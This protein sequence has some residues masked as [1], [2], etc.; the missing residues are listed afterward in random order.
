MSRPSLAIPLGAIEGL[1][2]RNVR[3]AVTA[4]DVADLAASIGAVDLIHPLVVEA[5]PA[6]VGAFGRVYR[7]LDG[8]RR[9]MALLTMRD[10]LATIDDSYRV[11]CVVLEADDEDDAREISLAANVLRRDLHPVEEFE[12]FARL[13]AEG[14]SVEVIAADFGRSIRFVRQ[15][16]A[17]DRLSPRVRALWREG[18]IG[19]DVA[20]AFTKASDQAGQDA[21]LDES[22]MRGSLP[23]LYEV[24]RQFGHQ[25]G[26]RA[27]KAEAVYVGLEAYQAAGGAIDDNLF[28]DWSIC[29]DGALL[30]R[31]AREKMLREGGDILERTG[32]GTCLIAD[33]VEKSWDWGR[34]PIDL[35]A[36]D[37][38]AIADI[39]RRVEDAE[40]AAE[41]E[42]DFD[43]L[44]E[45]FEAERDT[46]RMRAILRGSTA[47]QR[48][49]AAIF[50]T[51]TYQGTL[52]VD[53]GRTSPKVTK[54]A[55]AAAR[56]TAAAADGAS[57][58]A[59][60]IEPERK[61]TKAVIECIDEARVQAFAELIAARPNLA[62][63]LCTAALRATSNRSPLRV[64]ATGRNGTILDHTAISLGSAMT[65]LLTL[66]DRNHL[67]DAFARVVAQTVVM[68]TPTY[69]RN[70]GR[71]D[72]DQ[73]DAMTQLL[74][75]YA[76]DAYAPAMT[77][78]LNYPAYFAAATRAA[79][80]AAIE[81]CGGDVNAARKLKADQ[82]AAQAAELAKDKAWL[83]AD[84]RAPAPIKGK[85]VDLASNAEGEAVSLADAMAGAIEADTQAPV[86]D[87][88]SAV[89][90]YL[91]WACVEEEGA[92][93]E[94]DDLYD[95]FKAG[96]GLEAVYAVPNGY[97]FDKAIGALGFDGEFRDGQFNY[98]G[99]RLAFA[100]A[101]PQ[102]AE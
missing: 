39:E 97:V 16:L 68:V 67:L 31:L 32:F 42:D 21:F 26:I 84:L 28:Q 44:L 11:P 48:A 71:A 92:T 91:S 76:R 82:V 23:S 73:V 65:E 10:D 4:A 46:I 3:G 12:A 70:G 89:A 45:S 43:R 47:D 40:Q 53:Y 102:A 5:V 74:A 57:S 34:L 83:P 20:A 9:Y 18:R 6:Q 64:A 90:E 100:L 63:L 33:D 93:V 15:R 75:H 49:Q 52:N 59:T 35:I 55:A 13:A 41:D 27:D 96:A 66:P 62:L 95:A 22:A 86:T 37:R 94:V 1:S 51:L 50:L 24:T 87:A 77:A 79:A 85:P 81:E 78:A 60:Q 19:S 69:E 99:L 98:S 8:G 2:D 38:D 14:K 54:A 72:P 88:E 17:L 101:Q 80:L 36:A 58:G 61:P 25:G 7:V 56:A 30:K 29:E